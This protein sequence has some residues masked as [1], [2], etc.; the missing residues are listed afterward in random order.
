MLTPQQR[1]ALIQ[2]LQQQ[3]GTAQPASAGP[4]ANQ[5]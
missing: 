4:Q 1:F 3:Q 5:H 2:Q